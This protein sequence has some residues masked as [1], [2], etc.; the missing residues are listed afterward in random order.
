MT[1]FFF[2]KVVFADKEASVGNY[3]K[4]DHLYM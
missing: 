2:F 3:E 4:S 1:Y